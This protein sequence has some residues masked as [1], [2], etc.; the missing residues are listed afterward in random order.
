[1]KKNQTNFGRMLLAIVAIALIGMSQPLYAKYAAGTKGLKPE[2]TQKDEPDYVQASYPGGETALF[3]AIADS[4]VYPAKALK[5]GT[6][7][8]VVLRF[9]IKKDGSI[10]EVQT[11]KSLSPECDEAAANAVKELRKFSPAKQNGKPI[12]VWYTL[13][14]LFKTK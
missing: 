4:L 11:I 10:G 9:H 14:V 5:D 13:P 12:E 6:Q 7:G 2:T 1:M 8:A 3:K